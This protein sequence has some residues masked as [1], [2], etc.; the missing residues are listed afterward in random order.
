MKLKEGTME[1]WDVYDVHRHKKDKTMRRGEHFQQGDYHLVVHICIFNRQNQLLIQQRQEGKVGFPNRWDFTAGGSAISGDTSQQAAQRE[2]FEE[3]GLE[4]DFEHRRPNFTLN[5]ENG[6]D[7]FYLICMELSL[8]DL[9]LQEEEVKA[10]RWASHQE[11]MTMLENQEFVPYF[12]SFIDFLFY[13]KNSF[14][15]LQYQD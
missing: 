2:L 10:V 3:I 5:F 13:S 7:D 12:P 4:L 11:I 15:A 9:R 6:F 1:F 8:E 14:G